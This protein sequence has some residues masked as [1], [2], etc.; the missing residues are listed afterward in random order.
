MYVQA[1]RQQRQAEVR[2]S[3]WQTAQEQ[4]SPTLYAAAAA[5]RAA[6]AIG[7]NIKSS[8]LCGLVLFKVRYHS[9]KS[10]LFG[11]LA[12]AYGTASV[13]VCT[14]PLIDCNVAV[15]SAQSAV[16]R[17][18]PVS[19]RALLVRMDQQEWMVLPPCTWILRIS[20]RCS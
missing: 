4:S 17:R 14:A 11:S 7:N 18:A 6:H 3:L 8:L 16:T 5:L 2:Q 19:A 20:D 13:H 10:S 9:C 1:H 12:R 15:A